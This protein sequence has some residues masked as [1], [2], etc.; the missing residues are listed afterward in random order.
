MRRT[1]SRTRR[2]PDGRARLSAE[3]TKNERGG[4]GSVGGCER[5]FGHTPGWIRQE[6]IRKRNVDGLERVD[7]SS[8]KCIHLAT[9]QPRTIRHN[10]KDIKRLTVKAVNS[11]QEDGRADNFYGQRGNRRRSQSPRLDETPARP[12][13]FIIDPR[14]RENKRWP[15]PPLRE[16]A[17]R[18][19]RLAPIPLYR[20]SW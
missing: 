6:G 11:H 7:A 20:S 16:Q 19:W 9:L 2:Q 13:A 1:T 4:F 15:P 10:R 12:L 14:N 5:N 17:G 18:E 3:C 8:G